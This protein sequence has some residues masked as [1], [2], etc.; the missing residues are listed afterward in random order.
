MESPSHLLRKCQP[1]LARGPSERERTSQRLK[2]PFALQ[3]DTFKNRRTAALLRL[4]TGSQPRPPVFHVSD[5][6]T[7]PRKEMRERQRVASERRNP[8]GVRHPESR[9]LSAGDCMERNQHLTPPCVQPPTTTQPPAVAGHPTADTLTT[10]LCQ[11]QYKKPL[12]QFSSI[13]YN[14]AR[15]SKSK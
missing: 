9:N 14:E 15:D 6:R 10:P 5:N 7:T 11:Q 2:A 12:A 3:K 4:K 8:H 13:G 1:P